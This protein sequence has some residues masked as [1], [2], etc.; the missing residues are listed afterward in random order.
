MQHFAYLPRVQCFVDIFQVLHF[1]LIFDTI[2]H[3]TLQDLNLEKRYCTKSNS[4]VRMYHLS[5]AGFNCQ[6]HYGISTVEMMSSNPRQTCHI[7]VHCLALFDILLEHKQVIT[8]RTRFGLSGFPRRTFK[9]EAMT[10]NSEGDYLKL[11]RS[12]GQ[13]EFP[14][15]K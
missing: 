12:V 9:L 5:L 8:F 4:S 2:M 6:H 15:L 14:S 13:R 10:R 1:V 3:N 7:L 11:T